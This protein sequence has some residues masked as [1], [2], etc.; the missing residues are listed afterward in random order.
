MMYHEPEGYATMEWL[1]RIDADIPAM[2]QQYEVPGFALAVVAKGRTVA[3]RGYGYANLATRQ[4]MQPNT[5]MNVASLSKPVTAW[6]VLHIVEQYRL[7]LDTPVL[8]WIPSWAPPVSH[9]DP[10]GITL[11]RLLSHTAGLSMPAVPWF[12]ADRELPTI[13][14]VLRGEAGDR[15]SLQLEY[16]PGNGW[17]YS[18]G[19]YALLEL[20]VESISGQSFADFMKTSMFLPL[21]LRQTTFAPLAGSHTAISYDQDG[22]PIPAYQLVGVAAGGLNSTATDLAQLLCAYYTHDHTSPG[23]RVISP[24]AL[25][26]AGTPVDRVNLPGIAL[27]SVMYG[28]GHFIHI[29]ADSTKL[30]Y[31]SGGNPGVRAYML[32]Q[33]ESGD[34]LVLLANSDNAVPLIETIRDHWGAAHRIDL[35]ILF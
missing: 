29:C 5:I 11:R 25:D 28:L 6:G 23:G 19:G 33:L 14:A 34:G 13:E 35:P 20:F 10:A 24:Q 3:S 18:G 21:G 12:P 27:D 16:A 26:F 8:S 30:L 9:F 15:G 4:S 22:A 31:H 2:L 7:D 17:G 1:E 32:A